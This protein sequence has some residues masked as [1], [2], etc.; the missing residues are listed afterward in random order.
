M[1][2]LLKILA[3]G[4]GTGFL[5]PAPGTWG[6]LIGLIIYFFWQMPLGII[7]FFSILGIFICQ[8]G[9]KILNEHDS[10]RIVF[11]EMVGIWVSL[12]NIPI[13]LYPFAF[14]LFRLFDI[15]KFYPI[16]NL[17]KIPGGLGIML[18]DIAAGIITRIILAVVIFIVY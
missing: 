16:D 8:S 9:E 4:F 18:D 6:T 7:V 13:I 10:P 14:L 11:D 15:K 3:T 1:N 5:K 12:W 17:E 2:Q